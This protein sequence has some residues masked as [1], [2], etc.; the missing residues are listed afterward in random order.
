VK[1]TREHVGAW[2]DGYERAWRTAGTESLREL[3]AA[4]AVYRMSPYEEP[5]IGLAAI[6]EMWEAE[7][8][9]PDEVFQMTSEAVAVEGNTAVVRVEVLYGEP[10]NQEFRDL[11]VIAFDPDGRC[12]SFEEWPFYP[13]QPYA[14][15][16]SESS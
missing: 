3:F 15:Q 12:A 14:P 7:R 6:E 11:W 8:Q 1:L 13:G 5:K 10:Y 16:S 4:N 9:G 2:V